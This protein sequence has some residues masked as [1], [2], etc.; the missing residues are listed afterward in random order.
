MYKR[1][2]SSGRFVAVL[3]IQ[4]LGDS[5]QIGYVA[6]G[7]EEALSSKLFQLKDVRVTSS[8]EADKQ[9]QK[10]PLTKIARNL[11]ANYLVQ[12]TLQGSGDRIRVTMRLQDALHD[13]R[14][15]TKEFDGVPTDLF[16]LEDQIYSDLV[17][18][19]D[20]L[21]YTSRCV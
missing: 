5:S 2:L 10:Q 7:V 14:I 12:G 1:Q 4:V 20:C 6:Q 15:W 18:A 17:A 21:L 11:G 8:D 19:L 13:K 16:T 9:D 3:P